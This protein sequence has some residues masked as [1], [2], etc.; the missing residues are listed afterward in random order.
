M[1]ANDFV[2]GG[3]SATSTVV[4]NAQPVQPPPSAPP[5]PTLTIAKTGSHGK[6]KVKIVCAAACHTTGKAKI[7]AATRRALHLSSRTVARLDETLLNPSTTARSL[8]LT[9]AVRR[10]MRTYDV[11]SLT[12]TVKVSA[13]DANNRRASATEGSTVTR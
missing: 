5:G 1:T 6:V 11:E 7:S 4:V 9:S 13:V 2:G 10:A 12:V 8:V 3:G